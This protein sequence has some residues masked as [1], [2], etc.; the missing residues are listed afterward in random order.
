M[1]SDQKK[2]SAKWSFFAICCLGCVLF[3]IF[4]GY[5]REY[6]LTMFVAM[7]GLAVN[8]YALFARERFSTA[9]H[10]KAIIIVFLLVMGLVIGMVTKFFELYSVCDLV[11]G[12]VAIPLFIFSA[13][14][15]DRFSAWLFQK[16]DHQR[17][18]ILAIS[19][20]FLLLSVL[21]GL[22]FP[23]WNLTGIV[24]IVLKALAGGVFAWI[25]INRWE[26]AVENS[27]NDC[28]DL[29]VIKSFLLP[30]SRIS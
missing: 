14:S 4:A 9:R 21:T 18:A 2:F 19:T 17:W 28:S 25:L 5:S 1:N 3:G 8:G 11:T 12:M 26:R 30:K 29:F 20:G 15:L 13:L 22:L 10:D 27:E 16:R 24:L 23:E 6:L 7:I